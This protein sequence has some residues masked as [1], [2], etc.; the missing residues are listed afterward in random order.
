MRKARWTFTEFDTELI[1]AYWADEHLEER[2]GA[3]YVIVGM[4]VCPTTSRRHLQG[5]IHFKSVKS[6]SQMKKILGSETHF[7]A[8][9]GSGASNVTYCS[10]E[11]NWKEWGS[12]TT[13]GNRTDLENVKELIDAGAS[14]HEIAQQYFGTWLRNRHSLK[15]YQNMTLPRISAPTYNLDDYPE[16]WRSLKDC[17]SRT[18]ILWG[19]SGIGKTSFAKILVSNALLVSHTDDLRLFSQ[20]SHGG[21]IFDDMDFKHLPRTSQ[22]HLVD[23]DDDRS[24]HCRYDTAFIPKGTLKVF[25][26]NEPD[27]RVFDLDD[28]AIRRRVSVH[29]LGYFG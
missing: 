6:F 13:Q 22:I 2:F 17:E 20:E 23:Q 28:P 26:T 16:E 7:E 11:G 21:I 15:A 5:Y 3:K 14:M 8:A 24:I 4:E 18:M 9:I 27:G 1:D 25:T 29:H 19:S 12:M 10:K